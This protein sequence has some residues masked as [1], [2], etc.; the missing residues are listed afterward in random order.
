M[1]DPTDRHRSDF[2]VFGVRFAHSDDVAA[3]VF[4]R[5][6]SQNAIGPK[7]VSNSYDRNTEHNEHE[8]DYK[9]GIHGRSVCSI[10]H[11]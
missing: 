8:E 5:G 2:V 7:N 3:Y 10:V 1:R 4:L 11:S 9:A 6:A